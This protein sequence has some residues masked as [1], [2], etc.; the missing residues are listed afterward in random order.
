LSAL[1]RL[2][3]APPALAIARRPSSFPAPVLRAGL[4][5]SRRSLS[6]PAVSLAGPCPSWC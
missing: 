6:A 1:F 4:V 3:C 2:L 5:A